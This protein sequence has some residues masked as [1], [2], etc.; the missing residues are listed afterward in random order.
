MPLFA[1]ADV[2]ISK[3]IQGPD[4]VLLVGYFV[5]MLGI[6]LYFYRYMKGMKVFFTGGN[7]IPWWL[8][9][10]SFYMSSFSAYAFVVFSGQCFSFGWVGLTLF[11]VSMPAALFSA[12]LFSALWRRARTRTS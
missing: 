1:Q 5:L 3:S 6:G 7:K 8:S 10:V 11:W 2:S 12:I 4:Y 9:G